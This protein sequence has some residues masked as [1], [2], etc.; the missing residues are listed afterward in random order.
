MRCEK[1][2]RKG[3]VRGEGRE[4]GVLEGRE[5]ELERGIQGRN[6]REGIE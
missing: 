1:G 3:E 4:G 5:G 2:Q 6:Q